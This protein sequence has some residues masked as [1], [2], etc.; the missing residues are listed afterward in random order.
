MTKKT[1]PIPAKTTPKK[2]AATRNKAATMKPLAAQPAVAKIAAD[3]PG[4]KSKKTKKLAAKPEI[5]VKTVRDSFTMPKVEYE[6]IND[7]KQTCLKAGL[8]VKKN[9]LLRAG[10]R[11]LST[12]SVTQLK[13]EIGKLD[14]IKTGRLKKSAA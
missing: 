11:A 14:T 7:L 9:E 4:K 12:L 5:K 1:I 13:Q 3:K 8:H 10:L 6:K 2:V